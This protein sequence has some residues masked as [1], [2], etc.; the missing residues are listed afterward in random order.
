MPPQ[1]PYLIVS[2]I[3]RYQLLN[4]NTEKSIETGYASYIIAPA[5]FRREPIAIRRQRRSSDEVI[6]NTINATLDDY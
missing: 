5:V 1:T 4:L 2:P 3:T 6:T